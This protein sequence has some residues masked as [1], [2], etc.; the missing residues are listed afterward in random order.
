MQ[1][2][3]YLNIYKNRTKQTNNSNTNYKPIAEKSGKKSLKPTTFVKQHSNTFTISDFL[4]QRFFLTLRHLQQI[5]LVSKSINNI[6]I[7]INISKNFL[8][9]KTFLNISNLKNLGNK[10]I[11]LF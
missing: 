5:T 10:F 8:I 2:F 3:Q 11:F 6:N 7:S 9:L 4:L 1:T